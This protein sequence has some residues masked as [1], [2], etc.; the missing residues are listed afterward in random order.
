MSSKDV[1]SIQP[2]PGVINLTCCLH[3]L[4]DDEKKTCESIIKATPGSCI[5]PMPNH[6][7]DQHGRMSGFTF[8]CPGSSPILSLPVGRNMFFGHTACE[9]DATTSDIVELLSDV[10]SAR[11]RMDAFLMGVRDRC[12]ALDVATFSCR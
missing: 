6:H 1:I 12:K 5:T 9:C 3:P 8:S 2:D 11:S 7:I 4:D 10:E